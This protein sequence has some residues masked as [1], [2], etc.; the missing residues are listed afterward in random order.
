MKI[1]GWHRLPSTAP[2]P[3]VSDQMAERSRFFAR[4]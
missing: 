1:S 2:A 3:T 4:F